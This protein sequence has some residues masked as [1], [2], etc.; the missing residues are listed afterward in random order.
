MTHGSTSTLKFISP[1]MSMSSPTLTK[2]QHDFTF[3]PVFDDTDV[4][5][6]K[7]FKPQHDLNTLTPNYIEYY[8]SI[9]RVVVCEVGTYYIDNAYSLE[10]VYKNKL[11]KYV[12]ALRQ[13]INQHNNGPDV[14][15]S[16]HIFAV[17]STNFVSSID[18]PAEVVNECYRYSLQKL[19]SSK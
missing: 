14:N 4:P 8:P 10:T 3:K 5:L 2:F 7:H 1:I 13:R 16:F 12:D 17:S 11:A 15:I 19:L 9:N 18:L 6:Y